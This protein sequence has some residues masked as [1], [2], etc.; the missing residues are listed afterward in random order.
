MQL[1]GCAGCENGFERQL[2]ERGQGLSEGLVIRAV[3]HKMFDSANFIQRRGCSALLGV[4]TAAGMD[5]HRFGDTQQ[6]LSV[7]A[8]PCCSDLGCAFCSDALKY[9]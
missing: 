8:A 6:P 7:L 9:P 4:C 5:G 1:I 3:H 2:Y